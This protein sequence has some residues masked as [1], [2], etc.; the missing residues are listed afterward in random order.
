MQGK[1]YCISSVLCVGV[2]MGVHCTCVFALTHPH[3]CV[4]LHSPA[5]MPRQTVYFFQ[6]AYSVF[7][8]AVRLNR[9]HGSL[10]KSDAVMTRYFKYKKSGNAC[11]VIH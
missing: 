10:F 1:K 9:L 4:V 8:S 3:T 7:R 6:G 2:W 5:L 11:L